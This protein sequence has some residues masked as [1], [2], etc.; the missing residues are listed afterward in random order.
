MK[1]I[2][3]LEKTF[4]DGIRVREPAKC[5]D[6]F[7]ISIQGGTEFH[8]CE[9]RR[10]A[11]LYYELELGFPSESDDLIFQFAEDSERPTQTVYSYVP[12]ETVEALVEKHGGIVN[13]L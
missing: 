11:N 12:I 2:E 13:I 1:A 9:P 6:G 3:F 7:T 4:H 10:N 8:Y 5:A